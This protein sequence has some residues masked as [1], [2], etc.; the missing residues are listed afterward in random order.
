MRSV[1][2]RFL[3][4]SHLPFC[5]L[6]AFYKLRTWFPLSKWLFDWP[7]F[8]TWSW[9][10]GFRRKK[11]FLKR[12]ETYMSWLSFRC[13]F[14]ICKKINRSLCKVLDLSAS[15]PKISKK[16]DLGKSIESFFQYEKDALS[17]WLSTGENR[18]SISP[19]SL[20]LFEKQSHARTF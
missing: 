20:K 17:S 10:R 2:T 3:L 14:R 16:V 13:W 18:R 19:Y 5:V 11:R 6:L 15:F 8:L 4:F 9:G 12:F 7:H 1:K